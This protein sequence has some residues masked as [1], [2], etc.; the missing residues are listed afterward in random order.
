[1]VIFFS[2]DDHGVR[3]I[4]L[5]LKNKPL[6]GTER[7]AHHDGMAGSVPFFLEYWIAAQD[8]PFDDA[9]LACTINALLAGRLNINAVSPESRQYRLIGCDGEHFTNRA[10][11]DIK[12][13]GRADVLL[14][15][16]RST[17][18]SSGRSQQSGSRFPEA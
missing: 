16:V 8:F 7:Y 9:N 2:D 1:M 14:L 13:R 11:R 17:P 6:P 15:P 4:G 10:K 3:L 18:N 5:Q 12:G